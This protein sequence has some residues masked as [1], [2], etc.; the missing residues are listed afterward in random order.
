M[1]GMSAQEAFDAVNSLLEERYDNWNSTI[2]EMPSWSPK[3]DA[4]VE[5]YVEGI[6]NV[7]RAN[8]YWR[9]AIASWITYTDDTDIK[10]L[11]LPFRAIFWG[12]FSANTENASTGRFGM[13]RIS[14]AAERLSL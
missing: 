2:Q 3:V 10:M 12:E 5:K 4:E 13:A 6:R 1:G 8:L 14:G 11:K 9:Y 7:V